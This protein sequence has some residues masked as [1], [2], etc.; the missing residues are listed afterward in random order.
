MISEKEY[1]TGTPIL[2]MALAE[3]RDGES[4]RDVPRGH[5]LFPRSHI[6]T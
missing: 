1:E 4:S 3:N 2:L 6:E 5:D